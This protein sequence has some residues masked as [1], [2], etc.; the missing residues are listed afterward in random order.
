MSQLKKKILI[1]AGSIWAASAVL[2]ICFYTFAVG[3]QR[4]QL[5]EVETKIANLKDQNS[6]MYNVQAKS[7][8]ILSLHEK[9]SEYAIEA[10]RW[11]EINTIITNTISQ[12][13]I[14][15]SSVYESS[16]SVSKLEACDY[17][18]MR[19]LKIKFNTS[20]YNFAR[21]VNSLESG[22]PVIFLRRFSITRSSESSG[23]HNVDAD[24]AVIVEKSGKISLEKVNNELALNIMPKESIGQ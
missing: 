18:T 16:D 23:K 14:K 1:I 8:K 20:F 10:D 11:L 9:F 12:I 7:E 15:D 3:P 17:L 5:K 2:L 13:G 4:A 21:F 24:L 6:D 19:S 22:K